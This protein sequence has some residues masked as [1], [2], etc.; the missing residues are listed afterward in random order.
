[1]GDYLIYRI[2]GERIVRQTGRFIKAE[3]EK[4]T[5]F[6]ISDF[7][8]KE[9][10]RFE[11]EQEFKSGSFHFSRN[12]KN[13]CEE[14]EEYQKEA[15]LFLQ[16][17]INRGIKKAVFSR[18]KTVEYHTSPEELFEILEK[19]Y[20]KAFVYLISGK[21]FGTW[22]GATPEI[23]IESEKSMVKTIALAGTKR[24]QNNE[25]WG[26]K[27]LEEQ[28]YVTRFIKDKLENKGV[29][30]LKISKREELV[31]G[32]V[33][34]LVNY[35][36]F[37]YPEDK[38][39][40]LAKTIH[41]TPAVSGVEQDKAIDLISEMEKYDRGF[42]TGIIGVMESNRSNLY[43]NLRCA[44]LSDKK[45]HLYLGGGFTSASNIEKEWQE[46]ERK[47]ETLTKVL[48]NQ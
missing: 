19:T 13:Y 15:S 40:E 11:K 44:Q 33:K 24:T 41:P 28:E 34:H 45:L 35:F 16:E 5:G 12:I 17:M 3:K 42:Y 14:K 43:V 8:K 1:M 20:P 32:P 29:E 38:I 26:Q 10:Y 2:P 21:S 48:K 18:T 27:E 47:A 23:L 25:E 30:K 36:S 4:W 46:T 6:I 9:I 22:I 39:E 7:K 37:Y 31:A